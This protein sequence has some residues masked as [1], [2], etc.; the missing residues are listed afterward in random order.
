VRARR[1]R[2]SDLRAEDALVRQRKRVDDGDLESALARRGG[3]LAAD[4]ARTD[5]HDSTVA[6]QSFTQHVTVGK[7]RR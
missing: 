3:D 7:V 1:D 6:L 5:D 4:P 2:R